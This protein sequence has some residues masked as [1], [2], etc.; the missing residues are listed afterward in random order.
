[1]NKN[2]AILILIAIVT[3]IFALCSPVCK[4]NCHSEIIFGGVL[5]L[6]GIAGA[7][8]RWLNNRDSK[9]GWCESGITQEQITAY[10][11][12]NNQGESQC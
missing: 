6:I 2:L 3:G 12:K 11:H 1:M 9:R 10:G 7:I 4:V 8:G 5:V